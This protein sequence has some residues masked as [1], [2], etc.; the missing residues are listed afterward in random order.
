MYMRFVNLKVKEGR[1]LD[2]ARY[3]EDR[4]IPALEEASGCLY[5]SLLKPSDD[6]RECV[7]MTMWRSK[8]AAEAYEKSGVYDELLD[9]S[10]DF[11]A[12][13]SEGRVQ[14][15]SEASGTIPTLQDPEIEAYPVEVCCSRARSSMPLARNS[16]SCGLSRLG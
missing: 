16:F 7:S 4:V 13:V 8:E 9:E 15:S 11:L 6:D 10:D 1:Q 12:E 14:S 2:L 3:Y 5:A